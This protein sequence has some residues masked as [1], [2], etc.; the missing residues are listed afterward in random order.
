MSK[1]DTTSEL[2]WTLSQ[3]KNRERYDA[4]SYFDPPKSIL[5]FAGQVEEHMERFGIGITLNRFKHEFITIGQSKLGMPDYVL[6][7][8]PHVHTDSE[9]QCLME[10]MGYEVGDFEEEDEYEDNPLY[11][12]AVG[13][14]EV[15]DD[16]S[17]VGMALRQLPASTLLFTNGRSEADK[18]AVA[19]WD[20]FE[21]EAY[22][23]ENS[24]RMFQD[25][26]FVLVFHPNIKESEHSR[27]I[28]KK[29]K[30]K[31]LGVRIITGAQRVTLDLEELAG[32]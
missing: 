6:R 7:V 13:P 4:H 15:F 20:S 18:L 31:G 2:N 11:V 10:L 16:P 26:D 27:A 9:F 28:A 5:K 23:V 22:D 3:A 17:F 12:L 8:V 32:R 24:K 29:A 14:D 30:G 1:V 21:R 25:I 19:Y